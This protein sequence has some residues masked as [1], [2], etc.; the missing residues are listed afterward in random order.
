M[1]ITL[2]LGLQK[3]ENDSLWTYREVKHKKKHIIIEVSLMRRLS[4]GK[5]QNF[6]KHMLQTKVY[7]QTFLLRLLKGIRN[8]LSMYF[9]FLI[10]F[11]F[12]Y[13]NTW[14][15]EGKV[16][17]K[18]HIKKYRCREIYRSLKTLFCWLLKAKH[19]KMKKLKFFFLV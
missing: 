16:N 4:V 2:P 13:F 8:L 17:S 9:A 3:K 10:C 6:V 14:I 11:F 19:R 5:W 1:V 18:I 7:F 15:I 12:I